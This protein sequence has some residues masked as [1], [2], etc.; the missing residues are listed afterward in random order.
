MIT[1]LTTWEAADRLTSDEF[2]NWSHEGA[3]AMIEY[4]EQLEHDM[5]EPIEFDRVA[6]RYQYSEYSSAL[7]AAKERGYKP[8]QPEPGEPEP[9]EG[10]A[11]E[12]AKRWLASE[13]R[14]IATFDGG[15]IVERDNRKLVWSAS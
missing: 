6:I 2:A 12:A 13:S 10:D 9:D 1:T 8:D 7:E 3:Q 4:L 14:L 5:G 15:V 11:E